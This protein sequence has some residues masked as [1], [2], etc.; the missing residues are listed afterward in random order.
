M[1]LPYRKKRYFG[2]IFLSIFITLLPFLSINGNQIFLLSFSRKELHLLGVVF[3]VEELYLLPFLLILLFVGIFFLTTLGGRL[4]CAWGCPQ[5]IFRVIYRDLIE[6]KLLKLRKSI[7]NKQKPIDSTPANHLKRILA[8]SLLTLITL[9]A[10]GVFLC[11]FIIPS[12]FLTALHEPSEHK[13]LLAFWLCIAGFMVFNIA[14]L[15]ENFCIYV[16]PYARVQSV[17]YDNDTLMAIYDAKR[18]GAIY[19]PEGMPKPRSEGSCIHCLECV[20]C[21]PTHIDIRK[22]MQLEC[23]NCLEC[24]DACTRVL[25]KLGQ[26][27]LVRWSSPN[28]IESNAKVRYKRKITIGYGV[29]LAIVLVAMGYMGAGKEPILVNIDR[30]TQL[31]EVRKNGAVDNFYVFLFQNTSKE[32]QSY[33]IELIDQSG[34]SIISPKEPIKVKA[35][36]KLKKVITLR[37]ADGGIGGVIDG[38]AD[39]R[40]DGIADSASQSDLQSTIGQSSQ[41]AAKQPAPDATT[42]QASSQSRQEASRRDGASHLLPLRFRIYLAN[43]PKVSIERKSVFAYPKNK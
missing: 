39:G 16:C 3:N 9:C 34:I 27:S 14:F 28:A 15:Q 2:Y 17:L 19:T 38:A 26:P 22:G 30:N 13:I 1:Q 6:T 33:K 31:Y 20:R 25:G 24:V 21:C 4:W 42:P 11:Y 12:D 41:S 18:G 32:E 37:A 43:Q 29:V 36:G 5:T 23:I 40:I 8:I 10:S 35:G 7:K